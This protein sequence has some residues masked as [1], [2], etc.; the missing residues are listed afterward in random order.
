MQFDFAPERVRAPAIQLGIFHR[1]PDA[2]VVPP[3]IVFHCDDVEY[4]PTVATL[5][6]F[7]A[8]IM[9]CRSATFIA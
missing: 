4:A 2:E 5:A 8:A 3:V 7:S 6:A 9:P 1:D